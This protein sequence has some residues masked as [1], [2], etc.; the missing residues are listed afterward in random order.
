PAPA[1]ASLWSPSA[2]SCRHLGP[3]PSPILDGGEAALQPTQALVAQVREPGTGRHPDRVLPH[4]AAGDE[5][6]RAALVAGDP[7]HLGELV[8]ADPGREHGPRDGEGV[9]EPAARLRA[10]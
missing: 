7:Q 6:G 2:Y 3:G 4:C 9:G 8:E 10:P 5:A 1:S